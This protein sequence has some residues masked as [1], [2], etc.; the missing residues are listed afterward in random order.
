MDTSNKSDLIQWMEK[1]EL[2]VDRGQA[3][4]NAAVFG[5]ITILLIA[6]MIYLVF[7]NSFA[8][9][10][11]LGWLSFG[12]LSTWI[13][14]FLIGWTLR[15]IRLSR[16]EG[17]L[18]QITDKGIVDFWTNPPHALSWDG[19]EYTEWKNANLAPVIAF[20]P[21]TKSGVYRL[22]SLIGLPQ[23]QYRSIYL[24]APNEEIAQFVMNNAPRHLV[25]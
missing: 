18:L 11:P 23:L 14:A 7:T 2:R 1:L 5:S 6:G 22:R 8:D 25:R 16:F 24:D 17:P 13:F 20:I 9:E 4:G 3:S 15:L 19:I 12:I 10:G 21:K